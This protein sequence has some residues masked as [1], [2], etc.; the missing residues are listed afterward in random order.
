M[1]QPS[2]IDTV[3]P[4]PMIH[5]VEARPADEL[6][7]DFGS[8]GVKDDNDIAHHRIG[9]EESERRRNVFRVGAQ[10]CL[11]YQSFTRCSGGR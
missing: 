4:I 9:P 11:P 3:M 7:E 1:A 6:F 10:I 8:D 2:K 5:A